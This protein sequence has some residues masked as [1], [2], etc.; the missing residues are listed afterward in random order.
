MSRIGTIT[1]KTNETDITVKIN[2]DGEGKYTVKT[3]IGFFDHMLAQLASHG[4]FDLEINAV[5]D[6]HI[7]P[8]HTI[9]DTAIGLGK[10]INA[11]LGDKRG[12]YRVGTSFVPMDEALA[13]VSL[14]LSGRPYWTINVMWHGDYVGNSREYLIATSLLEHFFQTLTVHAGITLHIKEEVGRDNHHIAEAIFKSFSRAL[15]QASRI[16]PKRAS[17]IPSTKG[18]LGE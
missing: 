12:I 8:H 17:M 10:A 18:T 1:R 16:D 13:F 14:D 3:G 7:D 4:C 6:L 2:L 9:E 11:A 15:D 5:G